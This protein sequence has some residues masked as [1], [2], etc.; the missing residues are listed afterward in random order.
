MDE[1][2]QE[3]IEAKIKRETMS[4]QASSLRD[5]VQEKAG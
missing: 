1:F 4:D 5:L 2:A 3:A